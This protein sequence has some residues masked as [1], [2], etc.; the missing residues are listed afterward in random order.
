MELVRFSEIAGVPVH[1]QR[2]GNTGSRLIDPGFLACISCALDEL[3][4]ICPWGKAEAI[5]SHGAFVDKPGWHG[6]GKGFD[7]T[8]IRWPN[9][10]EFVCG[11]TNMTDDWNRYLGIEATLRRFIPQVLGWH[12]K[13]GRHRHH[14][15]LDARPV[16]GFQPRSH[17][18]VTFAQ[19]AMNRIWGEVLAVDGAWGPKSRASESDIMYAIGG[20]G[21]SND[22]DWD[23]FLRITA[24]MALW[25][26]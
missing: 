18:D 23:L 16:A 26:R 12:E 21:F 25:A 24:R 4:R 9:G 1:W 10:M 11:L 22:Q 14:W 3:W 13:S 15:H 6:I 17:V 7:L 8:G 2:W 20:D 5:L 19:D